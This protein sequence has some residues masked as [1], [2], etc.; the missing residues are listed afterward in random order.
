MKR[1]TNFWLILILAISIGSLFGYAV[2][3]SIHGKNKS[4]AILKILRDNCN[5]KE[6]NQLIY[7]KGL[8]YGPDGITTEKVEYELIDC[9]NKNTSELTLLLAKEVD[10]FNKIDLV[11]L[12]F[13]T[14]NVSNKTT[15]KNGKIQP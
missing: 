14:N 3:S 12:D 4:D 8:Q 13:I 7:V 2:S 9:I 1:G 10:G 15:I 11:T 6:V 5:C